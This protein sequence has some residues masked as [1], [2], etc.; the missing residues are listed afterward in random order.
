MKFNLKEYFVPYC[1]SI[2]ELVTNQGRMPRPEHDFTHGSR[3]ILVKFSLD[4]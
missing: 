2:G 1:Q 3:K 4:F